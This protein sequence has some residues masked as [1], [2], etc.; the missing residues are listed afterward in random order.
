MMVAAIFMAS[1]T[2][3]LHHISHHQPAK[4][5]RESQLSE[6]FGTEICGLV[7]GSHPKLSKRMPKQEISFLFGRT[8]PDKILYITRLISNPAYRESY[9]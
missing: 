8:Y 7:M 6:R 4:L 1:L 5:I 9:D 3:R 2:T